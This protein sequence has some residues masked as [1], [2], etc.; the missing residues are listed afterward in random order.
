[1]IITKYVEF[2]MGHR[3]P[4]HKSKC[5]NP[6]GH[7]Y[8]AEVGLSG[9]VIDLDGVSENGMIM[10]FKDIKKILMTEVHDKLDH[11]FMYWEKDDEMTE[12]Y[13][14]NSQFLSIKVPF[15]PTAENIA[16][17]L[18]NLLSKEYKHK[19]DNN[20]KLEYLKLWET[21]TSVAIAP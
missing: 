17:W 7:R 21:P 3:V 14:K 4:Y 12:F 2:D 5:R 1:M 15:T 13:I 11:G 8:R 20:L 9:D 16:G 6:H 18:Y 10:D 19:Y